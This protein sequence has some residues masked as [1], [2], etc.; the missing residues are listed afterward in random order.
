M[1]RLINCRLGETTQ[2]E[3]AGSLY[4]GADGPTLK[5][6][7]IYLKNKTI[8]GPRSYR[9]FLLSQVT[10]SSYSNYKDGMGQQKRDFPSFIYIYIYKKT[11]TATTCGMGIQDW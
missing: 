4:V 11:I 3:G 9:I 8:T 2:N 5:Q 7:E 10:L 6:S 1:V